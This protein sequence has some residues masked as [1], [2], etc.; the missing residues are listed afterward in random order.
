MLEEA[1]REKGEAEVKL[2]GA[3]GRANGLETQ[4]TRTEG[5]RKELQTRLSNLV[6]VLQATLGLRD[7][8]Q[9]SLIVPV[10]DDDSFGPPSRASSP[11][12][13]P[14]SPSRS[15]L[16]RSSSPTRLLGMAG[17]NNDKL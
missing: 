1:G 7:L 2:S 16:N 12:R 11:I 8:T 9:P 13:R 5:Q 15:V 4:L 3:E 14:G 10:E 6:S 17:N